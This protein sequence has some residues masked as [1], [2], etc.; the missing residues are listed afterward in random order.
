LVGINRVGCAQHKV[1]PLRPRRVR[2]LASCGLSAPFARAGRRGQAQRNQTDVHGL[3]MGEPSIQ[4]RQSSGNSGRRHAGIM[5]PSPPSVEPLSS[6]LLPWAIPLSPRSARSGA[7]RGM[8][9]P[10]C[11]G[12]RQHHRTAPG[13][14]GVPAVRCRSS[15]IS[16]LPRPRAGSLKAFGRDYGAWA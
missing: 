5:G 14:V 11:R 7:M 16:I 6:W 13:S 12:A 2:A 4:C 8:P 10:P 9:G 1:K 3:L 15:K